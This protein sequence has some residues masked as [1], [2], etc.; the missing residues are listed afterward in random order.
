MSESL[1]LDLDKVEDRVEVLN[2]Y[3]DKTGGI[4]WGDL[5]K[6]DD[7]FGKKRTHLIEIFK[8]LVLN[9]VLFILLVE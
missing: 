3:L 4:L 9:V 2:S 7:L 1:G 8:S 6:V 5:R